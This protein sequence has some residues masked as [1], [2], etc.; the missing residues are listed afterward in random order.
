MKVDRIWD[1]I[2]PI[3]ILRARDIQKSVG[4]DADDGGGVFF[5]MFVYC[6]GLHQRDEEEEAKEDIAT[7]YLFNECYVTKRC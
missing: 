4:D 5:F 6:I 2:H 3:P 7:L 1:K